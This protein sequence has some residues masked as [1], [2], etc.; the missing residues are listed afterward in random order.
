MRAGLRQGPSQSVSYLLNEEERK[1]EEP[2]AED[3]TGG[4]P[5]RSFPTML[6][7]RMDR[8]LAHYPS[9]LEG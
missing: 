4:G 2:T 8:L 6:L 9:H 1:R 5:P 7:G 3:L